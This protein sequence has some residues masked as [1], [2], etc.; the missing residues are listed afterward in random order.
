MPAFIDFETRS[1]CDLKK[2]GVEVYAEHGTTEAICLSYAIGEGTPK[3]FNFF[4]VLADYPRDLIEHV[5]AGGEVVAHNARF[6]LSI[7]RML[8]GRSNVWPELKPEQLTDTMALALAMSLPAGLADLARALRLPIEK[9]DAGHRLMMQMCKPRKPRKGE[10][11]DV[12]LW[13][14]DPES[15]ARLIQYCERDVE[16]ERDVYRILLPLTPRERALW[17]IDQRINDRGV[18]V[19]LPAVRNLRVAAT[20]ETERMNAELCRLTSGHVKTANSALALRRWLVTEGVDAADLRKDTVE[21]LLAAPDLSPAARRA[22][23]VRQE[24]AKSSTGKLDAMLKGAGADSRCRGILAFHGAGTGRWAGRRLQ[25][26]NMPRTPESFDVADAEA[27]I[28]MLSQ[29]AGIEATAALYG[30]TMDAVSWSLRSLIRS[31]PGARLLCADYSNIEGRGLAWLAGEKWKLDAFTAYDRGE[32]ADLYKVAYSKSFG[33]PVDRVTKD[34]RQIGKVQELA[35]GYQG[36]HGAFLSMAKNYRIDLDKIAA[37]VQRA[38]SPEIWK[39]AVE[40]YWRG[41]RE[42]AEELLAAARL[43]AVV[44]AENGE[45]IDASMSVD[46]LAAELA[47]RNRY[48][49]EPGVWAAVR[50]IVDGWRAAHGHVVALWRALEDAA[51]SAVKH[52]GH[53]VSA[54]RIRYLKT[55]D[56]LICRL[57]SGRPIVYPYARLVETMNQFTGRPALKLVYEGTDSRTRKWRTQ[58]AYGGLLAENVTQ[59]AARCVLS[60][61]IHRLEVVGYPVVLHVHDEIVSEVPIGHGS[62]TN[63]VSLMSRLEPWAEGFPVVASG[64]WEGERYRK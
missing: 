34:D 54:G 4:D 28:A 63:F 6:E 11:T 17:A 64:E 8:R 23:E 36:G 52:P 55:G 46:E 22:I 59:A 2:C 25:P 13:K 29:P 60:D 20:V 1:A 48:G 39:D 14:D 41:A 40:M 16:V 61:A 32:G 30:N 9:D 58:K 18:C 26:Q 5:A 44:A 24:A 10:P 49:L 57:P 19:D 37:A 33:I 47:R 7:W 38:V 51:I 3:T 15:V 62:L 27:I 43:E 56:F 53:V 31:G 50:I 45:E 35:L 42:T 21:K 12:L